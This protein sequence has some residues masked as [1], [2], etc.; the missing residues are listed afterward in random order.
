MTS[1]FKHLKV[2]QKA[3]SFAE[4]IYQYTGRFPPAERYGLQSQIRR[5]VVSISANIAEGCGKST[6]KDFIRFLHIAYGSVKEVEN[7]LI[8]ASRL[9]YLNNTQV[10]EANLRCQEVSKMLFSFIRTLK[11]GQ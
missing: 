8:L 4:L 5:A 6:K 7:Y 1:D 3:M 11:N 10:E 9:K 2:W